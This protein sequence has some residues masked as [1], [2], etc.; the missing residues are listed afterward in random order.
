MKKGFTL[1]ELLAVIVILAIIALIASPIVI[2]II[3]DAKQESAKRSMEAAV[4]ATKTA[5]TLNQID[6]L[7]YSLPEYVCDLDLDNN[8][9]G[10]D[11]NH[12]HIHYNTTGISYIENTAFNGYYCQYSSGN[13]TCQ[14]TQ[15]PP[16]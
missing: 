12:G 9:T 3:E 6:S 2:S 7:T 5:Y 13:I 15:F 1:I 4:S 16:D 8:I 11:T 10:C 14:T